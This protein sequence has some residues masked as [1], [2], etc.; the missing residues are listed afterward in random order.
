MSEQG[1]GFRYQ[2]SIQGDRG[3]L[4]FL[5]DYINRGEHSLEVLTLVMML[6]SKYPQNVFLLRGRHE[7]RAPPGL[8][9]YDHF[10][11][12]FGNEYGDND[13]AKEVW[14]L[15]EKMFDELS[16]LATINGDVLCTHGGF[17]PGAGAELLRNVTKIGKKP[18]AE[19]S[20]EEKDQY[21]SSFECIVNHINSALQTFE[22][23]KEGG[24]VVGGH[25]MGTDDVEKF[26]KKLGVSFIIQG[27][28]HLPEGAK[29]SFSEKVCT[30]FSAVNWAE[31]VNDAGSAIV[32]WTG[33]HSELRLYVLHAMLPNQTT[34]DWM[35]DLNSTEAIEDRSDWPV[36]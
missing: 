18:W 33:T 1:Y 13:Q 15:I 35:N 20:K 29:R 23:R 10:K 6:K 9:R 32:H 22:E 19:M 11:K 7:L 24:V 8:Y 31:K 27:T 36:E 30:I 16:I 3:K 12:E 14:K 26:V 21:E 28:N 4:L 17:P 25:V 2:D 5:G 34:E